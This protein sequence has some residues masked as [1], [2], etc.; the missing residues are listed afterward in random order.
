[1]KNNNQINIYV[2]QTTYVFNEL[3]L[4]NIAEIKLTLQILLL[5]FKYTRKIAHRLLRLALSSSIR[6]HSFAHTGHKHN[7]ISK[8]LP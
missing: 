7:Y 6:L 2:Y 4:I 5:D 3:I 1:M 8:Y